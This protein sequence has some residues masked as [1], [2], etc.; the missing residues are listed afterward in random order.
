MRK[1]NELDL[2]HPVPSNLRVMHRMLD[3]TFGLTEFREGQERVIESVLAGHNTLAVMPTG[4]GKSLCYQLTG[5]L[6]P[7]LCIVVSPL[8]S[9][10][11]DRDLKNS[12]TRVSKRRN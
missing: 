2:N 6:I 10:A 7:G 5:L 4:A 12:P 9:L 8:I 3:R 1:I 11:K